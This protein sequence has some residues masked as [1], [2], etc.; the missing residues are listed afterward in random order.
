MHSITQTQLVGILT[1][2][3][4]FVLTIL[5]AFLGGFF[6]WLKTK[7]ANIKN[8]N[9]RNLVNYALDRVD[10][11]LIT[12]MSCIEATTK[13]Q[14]ALSGTL[15]SNALKTLSTTVI[16]NVKSQLGNKATDILK[17]ELGDVDSYL[18]NRLEYLYSKNKADSSSIIGIVKT[19]SSSTTNI[20]TEKSNSNVVKSH[21]T[22]S[23]K[24]KVDNPD[25]VTVKSGV[26]VNATSVSLPK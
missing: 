9:A 6:K 3:L 19:S 2:L 11:L 17:S 18:T 8:E 23:S 20:S 5:A 24:V 22:A 21:T 10:N 25:N 16:S 7:T 14:L 13:S 12:N 1:T 26:T 15:D 4:P